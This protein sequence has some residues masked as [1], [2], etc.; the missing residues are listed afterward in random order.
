MH[1]FKN[2][3][4]KRCEKGRGTP[5]STFVATSEKIYRKK[6]KTATFF[7][8]IERSSIILIERLRMFTNSSRIAEKNISRK[9]TNTIFYKCYKEC[10]DPFLLETHPWVSDLA[11][12]CDFFLILRYSLKPEISTPIN[13]LRFKHR[14]FFEGL[15]ELQF[16]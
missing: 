11:I 7:G 5:A 10:A 14:F 3:E 2:H 9:F 8:V 1:F 4:H 6:I 13:V 16:K 15:P 12:F